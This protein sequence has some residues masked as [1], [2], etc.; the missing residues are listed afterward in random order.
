ML[1]RTLRD[2]RLLAAFLPFTSWQDFHALMNT[3]RDCRLGLWAIDECRAVILSNFVPAYSYA[4]ESAGLEQSSD[5]RL[6]FHQFALL[7]TSAFLTSYFY[8]CQYLAPSDLTIRP[9][10]Y[11]SD[12]DHEGLDHAQPRAR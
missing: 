12:A 4:L 3:S 6:D 8:L 2:P 5:V 11:V 1:F 9:P 7:S 10:A